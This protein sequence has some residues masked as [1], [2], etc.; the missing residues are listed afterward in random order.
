MTS[1]AP[2]IETVYDRDRVSVGRSTTFAAVLETV[3][4][5]VNVSEIVWIADADVVAVSVNSYMFLRL[6]G[7]WILPW[8]QCQTRLTCQRFPELWMQPWWQ[9]QTRLMFLRLLELLLRPWW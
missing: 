2:I 3:S 5:K 6:P 1:F 9:C 4:A 8:W 7:L